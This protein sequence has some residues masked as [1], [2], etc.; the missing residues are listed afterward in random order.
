MIVYE[1]NLNCNKDLEFS[2]GEC[3][4]ALD[5][6]NKKMDNKPGTLD[7]SFLHS[8]VAKQ[9]R[10]TFLCLPANKIFIWRKI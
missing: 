1:E 4:Q 7:Y 9:G 6:P 3:A 10:H 8:N 2:L 5:E